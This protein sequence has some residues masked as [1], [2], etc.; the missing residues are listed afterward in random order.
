MR[1]RLHFGGLCVLLLFVPGSTPPAQDFA[2]LVGT[3]GTDTVAV[4]RFT[5]DETTLEGVLLVRTPRTHTMHYKALLVPGG[6]F[7][8][9]EMVWRDATG[10]EMRSARITF[11][12]DS[13]RSTWKDGVEKAVSAAPSL[14][15]IPLPPRPYA[16][17]AYSLLEHAG[18]VVT[19][20][21]NPVSGPVEWM[22]TG[23]TETVEGRARRM[24]GDTLEIGFLEGAVRMRL[25]ESGRL[26]WLSGVLGGTA[27]IL[28]RSEADVD[29][30]ALTASF[31]RRDTAARMPRRPARR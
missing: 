3:A 5:R 19:M 29:L 15:A 8:Q 31:A 16:Y 2:T 10:A 23:A 26:V 14:G 30:A 9:L 12:V 1:S 25:G 24:R 22:L 17:Q 13:I 21:K 27:I 4:D 6:R 28:Q 18:M 7:S 20:A 11:G